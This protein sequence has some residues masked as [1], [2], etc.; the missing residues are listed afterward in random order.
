M[1]THSAVQGES[2]LRVHGADYRPQYRL[3]P[4]LYR[5]PRLQLGGVQV[6]P[7]FPL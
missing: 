7:P 6:S 2:F 4:L 5:I 1:G 3:L